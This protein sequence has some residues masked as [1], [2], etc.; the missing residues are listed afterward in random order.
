M[1]VRPFKILAISAA[2]VLSGMSHVFAGTS[3]AAKEAKFQTDLESLLGA[4][5]KT[6]YGEVAIRQRKD[7]AGRVRKQLIVG[8]NFQEIQL[9]QDGDGSVD[10]WMVRNKTKTVEASQP[11]HGR[12]LRIE[13]KD[14][15][16][17]G[18]RQATYLLNTDGRS[19]SLLSTKFTG[20]NIRA[21]TESASGSFKEFT[22]DDSA[23]PV[24]LSIRNVPDLLDVKTREERFALQERDWITHQK[25]VLGEEAVCNTQDPSSTKL[26]ELQRNWWKFLVRDSDNKKEILAS[27]LKAGSV[28]GSS[29]TA[30][31][32]RAELNRMADALASV[33]MSSSKGEPKAKDG[34]RGSYMSCLENSGLGVLAANV[35]SEFLNALTDKNR[36][37]PLVTCEFKAGDEGGAVPAEAGNRNVIVHMMAPEEGKFKTAN[38][39]TQN[40]ENIIFHEM[41]H[42]AGIPRENEKLAHA[43]QA[44]C[45]DPSLNKVF[46]CDLLDGLVYDEKRLTDI[47]TN[48]S[49]VDGTTTG[50]VQNLENTFGPL[51]ADGLTRA[52]FL[53]IDE[54]DP[55]ILD[56]SAFII[57]VSNSGEASCRQK[58]SDKISKYFDGFFNNSCK[59]IVP[60][61]VGGQCK[62]FAASMKSQMVKSMVSSLLP[63][64]CKSKAVATSDDTSGWQRTVGLWTSTFFGR[65]AN[66]ADEADCSAGISLPPPKPPAPNVATDN[67]GV[68]AAQAN[69]V[70][71]SIM[72]P[73]TISVPNAPTVGTVA[74]TD[75]RDDSSVGHSQPRPTSPSR[76][77]LPVTKVDSSDGGRVF[78]EDRYRRATDFAGVATKGFERARDLILP[79]AVAASEASKNSSRSRLSPDASFVAFKPAKG[80]QLSVKLDNPFSAMRGVASLGDIQSASTPSNQ[81]SDPT[82]AFASSGVTAGGAAGSAGSSSNTDLGTGS[83]NATKGASAASGSPSAKAGGASATSAAD[84]GSKQSPGD[85]KKNGLA[86]ASALEGMFNHPYREIEPRLNQL[87]VVE[88][89]ISEKLSILDAHKR[90]VGSSHPTVC[91]DYVGMERPLRKLPKCKL[92]KE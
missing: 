15:V 72:K 31:A 36:S 61:D 65:A 42:I 53:G 59:K 75:G 10:Y 28:F 55:S 34:S 80:E 18:L 33:M 47:I 76:S 91:Y 92:G 85:Q 79:S 78:A 71:G 86:A 43:A 30:A 51:T 37:V 32:N 67:G 62:K 52:F 82:T 66:A 73:K 77:P 24:D 4:A 70:G 12:F 25:S 16:A 26:A 40:Y 35:E 20:K 19:Y 14:Q 49:R 45:G 21:R 87:A 8:L 13:I 5:V 60:G 48:L 39:S 17:T 2:M 44:C 46:A 56:S 27:K 84:K 3:S 57:C 6:S 74:G 41:L 63:V 9:D 58:W 29:C 22:P 1:P 83:T 38:G 69:D 11:S 23:A 89:L 50:F 54:A 81:K 88:A 68:S 7:E 90:K 64:N